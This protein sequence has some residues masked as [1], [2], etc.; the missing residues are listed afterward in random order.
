MGLVELPG[1]QDEVV[2]GGKGGANGGT[3]RV[4]N[5]AVHVAIDAVFAE[6]FIDARVELGAVAVIG[7]E[8]LTLRNAV[9]R[10]ARV[11]GKHPLMFPMPVWFHTALGWSVERIMRVP[12]VSLAQVRMLA[13]GLVAPAPPCDALPPELAP[14]TPFSE[15]QI[16]KGLPQ[17]GPFGLHD[18]RCCRQNKTTEHPHLHRVFFEMS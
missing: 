15:E 8:E 16:R 12:L 1:V 13:E 9:R 4:Q 17:P 10:V 18:L 11:V 2:G 6:V 7:P 14:R 5:T 3:A